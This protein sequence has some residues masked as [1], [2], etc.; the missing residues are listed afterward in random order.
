MQQICV[1]LSAGNTVSKLLLQSKQK[2]YREQMRFIA[3]EV[4]IYLFIYI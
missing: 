2:Q 3:V 1:S 4:F